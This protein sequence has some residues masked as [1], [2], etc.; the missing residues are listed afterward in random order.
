MEK[1][2]VVLNE[3]TEEYK[4]VIHASLIQYIEEKKKELDEGKIDRNFYYRAVAIGYKINY[5]AYTG[6]KIDDR[7]LE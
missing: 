7:I 4:K 5:E 2:K 6:T 3:A 1:N